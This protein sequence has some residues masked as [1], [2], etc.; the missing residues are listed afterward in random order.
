[1]PRKKA[2][3]EKQPRKIR[4]YTDQDV[5]NAIALYRLYHNYEEVSR[6]LRIPAPT[7]H[8]WVNNRH[9]MQDRIDFLS[10]RVDDA[11]KRMYGNMQY[12]MDEALQQIH[13]RL[14]DASA[15]QA[16]TIFG[17]LFDKQQVMLGN[18]AQQTT[19]NIYIDTG[20]MSDED[21]LMLMQRALDRKREAEALE[22]AEVVSD[23]DD[24]A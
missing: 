16:A 20:G 2:G 11:A 22:A 1:M 13:R 15:A 10:K 23:G 7:I 21:K 12:V 17:I 8:D 3:E 5:I 6:E 9:G 18:Q 19:N 4:R 14:G 24:G